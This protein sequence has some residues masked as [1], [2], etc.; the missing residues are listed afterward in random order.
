MDERGGCVLP[1]QPSRGVSKRDSGGHELRRFA[2]N[3]PAT[4]SNLSSLT[5][6][7]FEQQLARSSEPTQSTLAAGLFGDPTRGKELWRM[8]LLGALALMLIEP[9]I[10]NKTLA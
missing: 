6:A 7:D 3:L 10:A 8:L 9:I 4:E 5:P 2:V 1:S